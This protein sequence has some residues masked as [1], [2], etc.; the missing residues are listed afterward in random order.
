M[1]RFAHYLGGTPPQTY[2]YPAGQYN[3]TTLEL[4]R[5]LGIRAAFTEHPGTVRDLSRPYELPRRRVRHDDTIAQFA[6]VATP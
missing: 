5:Q 6:S 1:R 4:M 3:A 2:A